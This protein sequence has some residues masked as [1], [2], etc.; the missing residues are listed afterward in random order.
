MKA[1]SPSRN[2]CRVV[3]A[4]AAVFALPCLAQKLETSMQE[5]GCSRS[6]ELHSGYEPRYRA[7]R[8][9]KDPGTHQDWL[10]I[11]DQNRATGPAL[12]VRE[13]P[14][15]ACAFLTLENGLFVER[16]SS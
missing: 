9:F 1:I 10:L 7:L 13:S 2:L 3:V 16:S 14:H 11:R 12:L 15:S 8:E 4:L 6:N 5:I